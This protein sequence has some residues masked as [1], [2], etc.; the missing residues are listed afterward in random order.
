M[1]ILSSFLQLVFPENCT[2]CQF[3]PVQN[4]WRL[5][6]TCKAEIPSSMSRIRNRELFAAVWGLGSY[7]GPLGALIRRGKYKPDRQLFEAL[8]YH[9]ATS[10]DVPPDIDAVV[11]VPMPWMRKLS[12]GFD[13]ADILAECVARQLGKPH[14]PALRRLQPEEQAA[15][16][17]VARQQDLSARFAVC[18][19]LP[20][21]VLLVD[22]V[23]TTGA[24]LDACALQLLNQSTERLYAVVLASVTI[25]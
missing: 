24:T 15:K 18:R 16:S 1:T 25:A 17:K 8:G 20:P 4:R 5:C 6:D 19:P 22:D 13:Q 3:S 23:F 9:L 12:R 7:R 21:T 14:I 11:H 2:H 10:C